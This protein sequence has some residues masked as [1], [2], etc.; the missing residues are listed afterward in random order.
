MRLPDCF[1]ADWPQNRETLAIYIE[2]FLSALSVIMTFC[3]L[4]NI[5]ID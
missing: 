5:L 1:H 3:L 2:I 4:L